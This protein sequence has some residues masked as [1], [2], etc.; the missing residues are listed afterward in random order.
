MPS[1]KKRRKS[2]EEEEEAEEPKGKQ[3]EGHMGISYLGLSH[4][5]LKFE[6]TI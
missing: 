6:M 4:C 1:W 3:E 5:L 2:I